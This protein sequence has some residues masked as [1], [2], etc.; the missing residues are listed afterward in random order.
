[1]YENGEAVGVQDIKNNIRVLEM[2][3]ETGAP[4]VTFYNSTG[5]KLDGGLELLNAT[6]A[7]TAEIARVSGVVPQIAVIT[8]TCAGTNAINAAAAD[9]CVWLKMQS[10][11]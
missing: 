7:L 5:A 9:V 6:A 11:S 2:A 1:M 10:F 3:A 4:V 8:G